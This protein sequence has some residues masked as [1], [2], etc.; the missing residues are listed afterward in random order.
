MQHGDDGRRH[1]GFTPGFIPIGTCKGCG[2]T[3]EI[4]AHLYG[5]PV[6][7]MTYIC[8]Q[9]RRITPLSRERSNGKGQPNG[10]DNED[11]RDAA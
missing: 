3:V 5:K 4:P 7:L 9:C 2:F 6:P 10:R 8:R 11:V 1:G